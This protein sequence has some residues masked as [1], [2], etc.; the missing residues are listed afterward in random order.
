MFL[1]TSLHRFKLFYQDELRSRCSIV[2]IAMTPVLAS[3]VSVATC[4]TRILFFIKL[5]FYYQSIFI[6][7][8]LFSQKLKRDT[9]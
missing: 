5:I 1:Q 2:V 9:A 7:R 4:A 8:K 6:Y 3:R